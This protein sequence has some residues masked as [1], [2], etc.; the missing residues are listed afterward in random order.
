MNQA[1]IEQARF[2]MIE[3]QVR[4]WD[5]LDQQVLDT[6]NDVPRE[7]FVPDAL[8]EAAAEC[9]DA[10][11]NKL[12]VDLGSV[13]LIDSSGLEALLD[14]HESLLRQG[15]WLKYAAASPLVRDSAWNVMRR[16]KRALP[17]FSKNDTTK[18]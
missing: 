10:R 3:Q 6:M 14:V 4:T 5:V 18:R 2:N 17:S 7:A 9:A 16:A 15:G 13:N 1:E 8:R 12:I 11:Q